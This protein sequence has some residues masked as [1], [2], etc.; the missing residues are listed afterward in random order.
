[1]RFLT[2]KAKPRRQAPRILRRVFFVLLACWALI[3]A[4]VSVHLWWQGWFLTTTER[5]MSSAL[6]LTRKA[7]LSVV[8]IRV[9]GRDMT[10]ADDLLA[11]LAVERGDPILSFSPEIARENI[12]KLPWVKSARIERR[13]PDTIFVAIEERKPIA[14]WQYRHKLALIDSTGSVL[15]RDNLAPWRA[16]KIVVGEKAADEAGAF[17]PMLAAEP[18]IEG[19]TTACTRI[20]NRR[21]DLQMDNGI[22]VKLPE[23]D[24]GLALARLA[25]MQAE[26]G[27]LERDVAAIDLRLSDRISIQLAGG[28]EKAGL[29]RV[30]QSSKGE[31]I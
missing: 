21:W 5:L 24:P 4:G 12:E 22:V 6:D 11:S 26:Y 25:G 17:L 18:D 7:G 3:T 8:N 30:S 13:L 14:L 9:A 27:I 20:G 16:L 15:E 28:L 29:M 10:N 1:M 23:D 31:G 2:G 19:H